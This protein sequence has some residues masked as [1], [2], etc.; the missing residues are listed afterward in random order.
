MSVLIPA[1][2]ASILAVW[3]V[4]REEQRGQ[5]RGLRE[6][7]RTFS[8]LVANNLQT[9]EG[10]LKTLANST[11]LE[12]GDLQ[13]FYAFAKKNAPTSE[14]AIILIDKNNKY[15]FN[16][17]VPFGTELPA[18]RSSNL[19]E[20]KAQHRGEQTLI[21]DVFR[22]RQGG[23]FDFAL[24]VPVWIAGDIK[25]YLVMSINAS[26]MQ[27]LLVQA[28]FPK[29]WLGVIVDRNGVIVSR[30]R[31]PEQFVGRRATDSIVRQLNDQ[32]E[33]MFHS[34]TLDGQAVKT[35]FHRVPHAQWTVV[36]SIPE[37]ELR[38]TPLRVAAFLAAVMA[39]LLGFALIAARIISAR[40]MKPME[41]LSESADRL[42]R[43]EEVPYDT[44]G[45]V[46]VD[47]VGERMAEASRKIRDH[48]LELERQVAQAIA[49]T[50]RAE[51]ALLQAQ[52]LE[53]VGR[54]TGGIAHEFNNLLQTLATA[55]QLAKIVSNQERVHSLIETCNKAIERATSLTS[56][57]SSFGRIQ[58]AKL[59]TRNLTTHIATAE[60]LL[61]TTLPSH[62]QLQID[63]CEELWP[64]KVDPTQFELAL[65]NL[66]I[67]AKDAMPAGGMIRIHAENETLCPPSPELQ[68]GDYVHI[69]VIDTGSGMSPEVME[70]A[71]DPF[72]TTKR[73]GEGTGL[74]LPQAYGFARQSQ[75][76]LL[77]QSSEGKGTTVSIYLPRSTSTVVEDR[78]SAREVSTP[79]A[80][81]R[82]L[83][84]EDDTLVTDAV[85]PALEQAGF[86]VLTAADADQ[87][88][89]V[90]E[91]GV[92]V[93]ALFSDIVMPGSTNG[94]ALAE[95]VRAKYPN[96]KVVLATGYSEERIAL[97][98]VKIL[99]KPYEVAQL[100]EALAGAVS[101]QP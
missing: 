19:P 49:S 78:E 22:A 25:Y 69:Q 68:P 32:P 12:Q 83:F 63:I 31:N 37:S 90:L 99:A 52:K 86:T 101:Y 75:G 96:I 46:E 16:T 27:S 57:L 65:I 34:V 100:V 14:T 13:G 5:E 7:T 95:A 77:L 24:Q 44:Q 40:V 9:Q 89:A 18:T 41:K 92:T 1:A 30:T 72:F 53:A 45:L 28:G 60:Q 79:A 33:G 84:V 29:E 15:L 94:R 88:L 62:V 76:V 6:A 71:L 2:L 38:Q 3:Y 42:G 39:L 91:S 98:G 4:Y 64:A 87:A 47:A 51:R 66:V 58:D 81:G 20:I 36:L 80:R 97:P 23:T 55:L 50:A 61:R 11:V 74:G 35:F 56:K 93:D 48:Q 8:L 59:E 17:R 67:N 54:L 70:K 82:L 73:I 10:I 85:V 43:G 21:S 26:E